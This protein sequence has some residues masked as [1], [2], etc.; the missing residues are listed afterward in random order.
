MSGR[1][2]GS[3][4]GESGAAPAGRVRSPVPVRR[5]E[6]TSGMLVE[7]GPI[8]RWLGRT[9]FGAVKF[10]ERDVTA[11]RTA[12]RDGIPVYVTNVRSLLDYLYFNY[13]FV[14]HA[15]P[16][17]AF[18]NGID[19]TMFRPMR[20]TLRHWWRGLFGRRPPARPDRE[21]LAEGLSEGRPC[22][23]SLKR[24]RSLIQFGDDQH[25]AWLADLVAIQRDLA[26]PLTLLPLLVVWDQKPESYRR[27][28]LDVVFGDPQAPGRLRKLMSFAFNFRRARAQVGRPLDLREFITANPDTADPEVLAAR[29]KFAM[30]NEFLLESKAIRGPV[31][32]GG[33]RVVD[34]LV[35]TP[36]FVEEVK[37]LAVADGASPESYL[38]KA[39]VAL[40]RMAADFRFSWLE[41]FAVVCGLVFARLF[42]GIRVDTAGL[43]RIR[44]AA[45]NGPIVLVPAHR[46][47]IDYLVYSVVLYTHG[48]IVP[49]IAAGD[50][51]SFWPMGPIF[52]H[53]GAF[54]I[55]RSGRGNPLYLAVLRHYVR[56]LLKEGYWIE[57]FI[58]GTR[59]RS[60][61]AISPKYGML[62]MIV[63]AVASGAAPDALLVPAAI[64]YERVIEEKAYASETAGG[65]KRKESFAGLARSAKVL[66]SRYGQVYV[67]FDEP[68]SLLEFLRAQGV[69]LPV[70][71]GEGVSKE[72]VRRLAHVL[73]HQI[74]DCLVVTPAHLVSFALLTH[75]K[76]GIERERLLERVGFIL[77]YIAARGGVLSDR[78]TDP[79]RNLGMLPAA[80]PVRGLVPQRDGEGAEQFG[81]ALQREID[82]VLRIF[83]KEKL[84]RLRAAGDD[85]IV[86]VDEN[87]RAALDYYKNGIIHFFVGE[88]IVA[89]AL[90]RAEA[91]GPVP[92]EALHASANAVS[93]VMKLEFI[94]GR[95][96]EPGSFER[97]VED[98][99]AER[100]VRREGDA[101]VVPPDARESIA[102]FA[103]V[104]DPF[105]EAYR[106]MARVAAAPDAP[107]ADK[108]LVRQALK[109]ARRMYLVGDVAHSESVSLVCLQTAVAYLRAEV[110]A[111][112]AASLREAADQMGR[113]L[114]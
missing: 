27:T 107:D 36:P 6:S 97:A 81:W 49:H 111:G 26:R 64:T 84:V 80:G 88:A 51:L 72:V 13:A 100:L 41:G 60:G 48:L 76:R 56:K 47:H 57:F 109:V 83:R 25:L 24:R 59:S 30:M 11:I 50:N 61:K 82:D 68:V 5:P 3:G 54:F 4:A 94:F 108:E 78:I 40:T 90:L 95:P 77:S 105:V 89:H 19:L 69:A 31:L 32:K 45:R 106:V 63:D 86:S 65:E 73:M 98:F 42:Q 112:R 12:A 53:C 29:L 8:L 62:S 43:A 102:F 23:L 74:N 104:L 15:L 87:A 67:E 96:D 1:S 114:G 93:R 91:A 9:F 101:L 7:A 21:T 28:F 70:E 58:E 16:L 20:Q 75:P 66:G 22:F 2:A 52:R 33:R 37:A 113:A 39:R 92:I 44:E 85:W 55:R 18:A 79:L 99:Q 10:E 46:S 103:G 14:R 17:A 71:S 110:E 38:A 35:R 34:E